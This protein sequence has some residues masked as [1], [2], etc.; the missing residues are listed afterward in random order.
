[1]CESL[2]FVV[3]HVHAS[4][5][6]PEINVGENMR[7]CSEY[8]LESTL[9]TMIDRDL[10]YDMLMVYIFKFTPKGQPGVFATLR[11]PRSPP[12]H[13]LS[14]PCSQHDLKRRRKRLP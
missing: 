9:S 2:R 11:Y 4:G 8:I 13:Y 5:L 7:M 14:S 10:F 6:D 3:G 12:A 1:M